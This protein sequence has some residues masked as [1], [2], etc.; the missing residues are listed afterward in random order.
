MQSFLSVNHQI[1]S[2]LHSHPREDGWKIYHCCTPLV[3]SFFLRYLL[4]W[5]QGK[6]PEAL[7]ASAV[8]KEPTVQELRGVEED[9]QV[10]ELD[11]ESDTQK[12]LGSEGWIGSVEIEWKGSTIHFCSP[13]MEQCLAHEPLTLIATRSNAALRH[14]LH[15]LK[16]YGLT[17]E[18]QGNREILIV[19]GPN[20]PKL[21]VSWDDV[22]LP[23]GLAEE[24][25]SNVEGFFAGADNYRRLDLPFRRGLLF[26]GPPGCG[27]TLTI[28][29]LANNVKATFIGILPRSDVDDQCVERAFD[30]AAAHAPAVVVL[31]DLDKLLESRECSLAHFLRT[32]DVLK[33]AS[34]ILIIATSNAP[35]KLDSALLHRPSRFDR[36]WKFPLPRYEQRLAL[37]RKRS[38]TF[39]SEVALEQAARKS[40]HFSMAYVQEI[41]VNALLSS[42]HHGDTPGDDAI[43]K[44]METLR[45]QRKEA[46][47]PGES[48][49]EKETVGFFQSNNGT[50]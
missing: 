1:Q 12:E 9:F 21:P 29:A 4:D 18:R 46:S 2:F 20:L 37:L 35:E 43:L 40:E 36:I 5:L 19:N 39:F 42:A 50:R 8:G 26:V 28:N 41:V 3:R 23:S 47:K 25:R 49:D 17:R 10:I 27:K 6:H 44:S 38:G 31:E 14:L 15:G 24:I 22:V 34:G 33:P 13:F 32:V 48:M 30:W 45:T 7:K 11:T 16:E